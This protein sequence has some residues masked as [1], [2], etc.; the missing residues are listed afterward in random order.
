MFSVFPLEAE[1]EYESRYPAYYMRD[2]GY[3]V[4][5]RDSVNYLLPKVKDQNQYGCKRDLSLPYGS[6]GRQH[7]E[8]ENYA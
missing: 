8:H 7:Y 2:L 3:A 4:Y 1:A 5:G 6:K